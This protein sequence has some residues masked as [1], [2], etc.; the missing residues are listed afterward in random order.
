MSASA[1][2]RLL[3]AGLVV[4]SLALVPVSAGAAPESGAIVLPPYFSE[5]LA[6]VTYL[7]G[8]T[9]GLVWQANGAKVSFL[10]TG[11]TRRQTTVDGVLPS[12]ISVTGGHLTYRHGDAANYELL[13]G[14][15]YDPLG[16]VVDVDLATGLRT[17]LSDD[18]NETL[19][20]GLFRGGT[21]DGWLEDRREEG[22]VGYRATGERRAYGRPPGAATGEQAGVSVLAADTVGA[23]TAWWPEVEGSPILAYVDFASGAWTVLADGPSPYYGQAAM[24]ASAI[25]WFANRGSELTWVERS[26]LASRKTV[27]VGAPIDDLALAGTTIAVAT[28]DRTVRRIRVGTLGRTLTTVESDLGLKQSVVAYGTTVGVV[29]GKTVATYG[30]YPLTPGRSTLGPASVLFGPGLPTRLEGSIGRLEVGN[31]RSGGDPV[32]RTVTANADATKLWVG[33]PRVLVGQATSSNCERRGVYE[34]CA[35]GDWQHPILQVRQ[36]GRLV[37]EV[38]R[39]E[40]GFTQIRLVERGLIVRWECE[41]GSGEHWEQPCPEAVRVV[42]SLYDL[43]TGARTELPDLA[44]AWGDGFGDTVWHVGAGGEIYG[45]DLPTA[46]DTLVRPAGPA[47]GNVGVDPREVSVEANGD[48]L[49]WRI[50]K[51]AG[52]WDRTGYAE[53]VVHNVRTGE[54]FDLTALH[55]DD[56]ST[57]PHFAA[58]VVGWMDRDD[59]EVHVLNLTTGNERVVGRVGPWRNAVA[60][61][62]TSEWVAWMVADGS[63][64]LLPLGEVAAGTP[65]YDG[66]VDAPSFSTAAGA[67]PYAPVGDTNRPINSWTMTIAAGSSTAT[68]SAVASTTTV[69]TLKGSAKT[70]TVAPRWDGRD[71]SGKRVPDGV[72]TWTL[73]GTGPGGAMQDQR[74]RISTI[75]GTVRVDS[76]T[77]APKVSGPAT[78]SAQ[79]FTLRWS[80]TE[81]QVRYTVKVAEGRRD[82]EGV[83]RWGTAKTWLAERTGTAKKY[84]NGSSTPIDLVKG[85]SYRFT[86]TS[87]D[88][89]GN[90]ATTTHVVAVR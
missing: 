32:V 33:E 65:R 56:N 59:H 20:F 7:E 50:D 77:P 83:L 88:R 73:T 72:Y 4:S 21:G 1:F 68:K 38:P 54:Q 51:D 19:D 16:P 24:S 58:G 84:V 49:R 28:T 67:D 60:M 3:V 13:D 12:K 82:A 45:R 27:A 64:H 78:S 39:R 5:D 8:S 71:A 86:V 47:A 14:N 79:G 87:V 11:S 2:R 10:A 89:A 25:V 52:W 44:T 41:D 53:V 36:N 37:L 80:S 63:V 55:N 48:W 30:V 43:D 61:A 15:E 26:D 17:V 70:G 74:G 35:A 31:V 34:A 6:K 66:T 40:D 22:L 18:A 90:V 57:W 76:K 46:V 69:R 85:R 29:A 23:V 62:L 81:R 42:A 75:T 9:G